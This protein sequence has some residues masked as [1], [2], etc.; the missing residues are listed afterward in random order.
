MN[1]PTFLSSV[2]SAIVVALLA[3]FLN[4]RFQHSFW[5]KQKLREQRLLI[6][7]RIRS[8]PGQSFIR[9]DVET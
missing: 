5:K 2:I 9:P 7:E 8:T 6:A 3:A 1:W 4:P